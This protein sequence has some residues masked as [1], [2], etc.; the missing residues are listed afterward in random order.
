MHLNV[1]VVK[2]F[3]LAFRRVEPLGGWGATPAFNL[4]KD[5]QKMI[6]DTNIY[7]KNGDICTIHK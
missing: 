6:R 4:R 1:L 7:S 5:W 3:L 2:W